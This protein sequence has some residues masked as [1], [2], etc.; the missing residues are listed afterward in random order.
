[1]LHGLYFVEVLADSVP[2]SQEYFEAYG[3]RVTARET[4]GLGV[5]MRGGGG[6]L[7]PAGVSVLVR[8]AVAPQDKAK[9]NRSG[10]CVVNVAFLV[11]NVDE[12]L[13][14][15][16]RASAQVREMNVTSAV[17]MD[18]G[19]R[20]VQ[21][22]FPRPGLRHV[23]YETQDFGAY[24]QDWMP[25]STVPDKFAFAAEAT[26]PVVS[27]IDHIAIACLAGTMRSIVQWY[28]T[29]LSLKA[30]SGTISIKTELGDGLR[31]ASLYHCDESKNESFV[32]LTFVESVAVAGASENQVTTFLRNHGGPG[33]QHI[34][35][36]AA[37]IFAARKHLSER[38]V[39]FLPAPPGYYQL[40]QMAAQA[41][42]AGISIEKL[43]EGSILFDNEPEK[44]DIDDPTADS[45]YLLQVF[46]R[47]P[48][49]RNT[50]FFELITRGNHREGFGAGN[51]RNLF[52]AV[53]LE[54]RR[55]T[56]KSSPSADEVLVQIEAAAEQKQHEQLVAPPPVH[57]RAHA[58]PVVVVGVTVCGLAMALSLARLDVHVVLIG[59]E[60]AEEARYSL[61][62]PRTM[63]A[64]RRLG[65]YEAVLAASLSL[66]EFTILNGETTIASQKQEVLVIETTALRSILL[67]E[68]EKMSRVCEVRLGHEVVAM[69]D[70]GTHI[71]VHVEPQGPLL[72][73]F[74]VDAGGLNSFWAVP[75]I[76]N[77]FV[78]HEEIVS[79]NVA[80]PFGAG[81]PALKE[82]KLWL[83]PNDSTEALFAVP[84]P[85]GSVQLTFPATTLAARSADPKDDILI[86]TAEF[87]SLLG[88]DEVL[89][90]EADV[91]EH[92]A[93]VA[94]A[95]R[96]AA[97]E[98]AEAKQVRYYDRM[99]F[100]LDLASEKIQAQQ[101]WLAKWWNPI[102]AL[103]KAI[104]GSVAGGIGR[105]EGKSE[106]RMAAHLAQQQVYAAQVKEKVD[107]AS[108]VQKRIVD[109]KALLV[110]STQVVEKNA[111]RCLSK[112]VDG[113]CV[114][115]VNNDV[116]TTLLNSDINEALGDVS[117]L[118]WRLAALFHG[119]GSLTMLNQY[120]DERMFVAQARLL[121]NLHLFRFFSPGQLS[122]L[123]DA[124]R[125]AGIEPEWLASLLDPVQLS[126]ATESS[127][128]ADWNSSL[129]PM[130][131]DFVI[132]ASL[133]RQT[134]GVQE[135]TILSRLLPSGG[136]S[137]LLFGIAPPAGLSVSLA[138]IVV[139][140]QGQQPPPA[141]FLAQ[142]S[143]SNVEVV[144]AME[145]DNIW[146]KYN[147]SEGTMVLL[148]PDWV[149]EARTAKWSEE[150]AKRVNVAV[151]G[152]P[153]GSSPNSSGSH[154]SWATQPSGANVAL[155]RKVPVWDALSPQGT[156]YWI[157][158]NVMM[159]FTGEEERNQLLMSIMGQLGR[160]AVDTKNIAKSVYSQCLSHNIQGF[161][162]EDIADKCA[163]ELHGFIAKLSSR[164]SSQNSL[165]G[166]GESSH[167]NM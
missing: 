90:V 65:V 18:K 51:I 5:W 111:S 38:G 92:K 8:D 71:A 45:Q 46:T 49:E 138:R 129:H 63:H 30:K 53:A 15:V 150:F 126:A 66:P 158:Y 133:M 166:S 80:S 89:Q 75:L 107:A 20:F 57:V 144:F 1:M 140:Q 44:M 106:V 10:S 139:L 41:E 69:G 136:Y 165:S 79:V 23:F 119:T 35:F 67:L 95:K 137:L 146:R 61:I 115:L 16:A 76:K 118:S 159:Q 64:W 117:A 77:A 142:N 108:T 54:R 81:K 145:P 37:D 58:A 2:Q 26:E 21:L 149:V 78:S 134:K 55:Q 25:C 17:G 132:D 56:M 74:V 85:D 43:Q 52:L 101:E 9:L 19:M 24:L 110:R 99:S 14:N 50:C 12:L 147:A 32:K 40:P 160:V 131:R 82:L 125:D 7:S 153:V 88:F 130:S 155:P 162:L 120:Q 11:D 3:L 94:E 164:K 31:L 152:A 123:R 124:V 116:G 113:R 22:T 72:A 167:S 34:A 105:E 84:R 102:A 93:L 87:C 91:A 27:F 29:A 62:G 104:L 98:A 70:L 151:F 135:S 163:N 157:L 86:R 114:F 96:V 100:G 122:Q 154:L 48:F 156:I 112:A 47:S 127:L 103:P 161:E 42:A 39:S 36:L 83:N 28:E 59:K 143:A 68:L 4:G 121:R 6:R 97:L 148:R 13:K 73:E 141:V 109:R 128:R 33:V 60:P